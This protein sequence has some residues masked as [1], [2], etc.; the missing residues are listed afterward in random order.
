MVQQ[1]AGVGTLAAPDSPLP[2]LPSCHQWSIILIP[3]L[4]RRDLSHR[5]KQGPRQRRWRPSVHQRRHQHLAQQAGRR[6]LYE[7]DTLLRELNCSFLDFSCY[8]SA[9]FDG[10]G[11]LSLDIVTRRAI[12][13]EGYKQRT[14]DGHL[15]IVLTES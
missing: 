12:W 1:V 7:E 8:G 2:E 6:R 14:T 15:G 11:I 4:F 13:G 10:A 3:P 9:G 5:V